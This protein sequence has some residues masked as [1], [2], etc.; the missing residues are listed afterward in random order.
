MHLENLIILGKEQHVP[1]AS[2]QSRIKMQRCTMGTC[3]RLPFHMSK[4]QRTEGMP[5]RK[6]QMG[7]GSN[8]HGGFHFVFV[9]ESEAWKFSFDFT[10]LQCPRHL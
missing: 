1:I 4:P 6:L 5:L 7:L 9:S 10:R 3:W 8:R 2:K